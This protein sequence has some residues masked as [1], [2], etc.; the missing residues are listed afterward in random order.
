MGQISSTLGWFEINYNQGCSPLEVSVKTTVSE[1]D[2][3][4]FQ[5]NG[6]DDPFP[7]AWRDSFDS[8]SHT[9]NTTGNYV[10]YLTVQ[11]N[12]VVRQ[13]SLTVSVLQSQQPVFELKNC[14]ANALLVDIQDNFYDKY[15]V[16]YGDGNVVTVNAG[17]PDPINTYPD[18]QTYLV[19]VTG[20]LN[21][22][23]NNCGSISQSF[24]PAPNVVAPVIN[25]LTV[26][27]S[28]DIEL[29]FSLVQN[30]DYRLE[31]ASGNAVNF[32][33]LQ[34]ISPGDTN[35]T[36]SGFPSDVQRF[37]FR[38]GASDACNGSIIYSNIVCTIA[39]DLDITNNINQLSWETIEQGLGEENYQ[40]GR[41]AV[42]DFITFP[43]GSFNFD[44][45]QV[46]CNT[47]YCYTV[48]IQY[49]NGSESIAPVICGTSFST[50]TPPS[51]ENLSIDI[52]DDGALLTWDDISEIDTSYLYQRSPEGILLNN[53]STITNPAFLPTDLTEYP[54][55]C[56]Q[57]T[58]LDVC[59]NLSNTFTP[60]CSILLGGVSNP[61]GSI[62]LA[63]SDYTGWKD[64]VQSYTLEKYTKDGILLESM[65]VGLATSFIDDI[66][67]TL[68]QIVKYVVIA[69][70]VDNLLPTIRSNE[71]DA[72]RRAQLFYPNAFTPDGDGLNDRFFPEYLFIREYDLNIYNRWG[73]LVYSSKDIE[74][75]WDGLISGEEG[76]EGSYTYLTKAEDFRGLK[77][78][79]SGILLLLRK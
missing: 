30:V 64:S 66:D 18:S 10:I 46:N 43:A 37:C 4:I 47:D 8:L 22:A 67:G 54:Q 74:E 50:D 57:H 38:I 63:W 52:R 11:T 51:I 9:Y 32:Q 26:T 24:T 25:I 19:Q 45:Q 79:R 40:I 55:T 15:I 31:A 34:L 78:S 56:Y 28:N 5:F 76:P 6:R 39:A 12:N 53:S 61:D 21:N 58:Y 33:F 75:G 36:L 16:D 68:D 65:P 44:D 29:D 77:I 49:D 71:I 72:A 20:R 13:D 73:E 35:L 7:V 27:L 48:S 17:A 41:N 69:T 42:P 62:S 3:P 60:I 59:G 23:P 14:S 1:S 2:V 70:P